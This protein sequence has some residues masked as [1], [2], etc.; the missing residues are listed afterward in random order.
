MVDAL[1]AAHRRVRRGG[2]VIDARPDASR[3]PRI[4]AG[5]RVRAHLHQS[6]DADRRDARADA[7]VDR[8]VRRGLFRPIERG[9]VWHI[10]HIGDLADLDAYVDD[11]ARYAGYEDGARRAL[12][13]FRSGPMAMRRAI[14]FAVLERR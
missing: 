9:I 8:V 1:R 14:K 11:S 2:L 6:E 5:G 12:A 7:A 10:S 3:R 13:A 4:V